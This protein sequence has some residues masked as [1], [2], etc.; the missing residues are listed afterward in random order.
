MI[1]LLIIYGF[2]NVPLPEEA[3][4]AK[5]ALPFIERGGLARVLKRTVLFRSRKGEILP[6]MV[7]KASKSGITKKRRVNHLN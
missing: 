5:S 4:A 3:F 6:S 1:L 7:I 2:P